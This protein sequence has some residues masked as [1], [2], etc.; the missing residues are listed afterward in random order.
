MANVKITIHRVPIFE[1]LYSP[2]GDVHNLV[3]Q[4]TNMVQIA[5]LREA[6]VMTGAMLRTIGDEI[7]VAPGR[8]VRGVVYSTDEAA[9]WVQQGTGV[10]GPLAKPIVPTKSR[11]LRWPNRNPGRGRRGDGPFVY[12]DSVAGQPANPFMWRGL[13]RGTAVGRQRWTLNRLI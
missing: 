5:T 10:H 7:R 13:V 1:L 9:L 2:S 8:S 6:P 11:A 3:E 12:R 4:T